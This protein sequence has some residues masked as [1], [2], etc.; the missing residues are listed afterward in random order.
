VKTILAILLLSCSA[1]WAQFPE[2]NTNGLDKAHEMM[3]RRAMRARAA[4]LTND[5]SLTNM[6][7]SGATGATTP[8]PPTVGNPP[9]GPISPAG[10]VPGAIPAPVATPAAGSPNPAAPVGNV[11]AGLPNT[12]VAPSAPAAVPEQIIAAGE[13]DFPDMDLDQ[14]LEVYAQ[15]VGK[16]L[17][18]AQLPQV[19]IKL[20]TQTP[21]T[22]T[23]AIQALDSV[24]AMNGVTIIPVGDKFIKVVPLQQAFQQAAHFNTNDAS[25]LPEADQYVVQI[26]QVKNFKPSDAIQVLQPFSQI[27]NGLL[28]IDSNGILI[29]RDYAANVKRMLE[30]IKQ[31]DVEVPMDF[32]SEVIPIKYAQASEIA[33]A[34]SSLGGS[35]SGSIGKGASVGQGG[36]G[37]GRFGN[38]GGIGGGIG[39]QGG[40]GG[41]INNGIQ[42]QTGLGQP[43]G[44]N[45]GGLGNRSTSFGDRLNSIIKNAANAGEIKILGQTKIIADLRTN[46][47]L[48]FADKQDMEMIK[49]I[50]A[51]LDVVLAQVLIES[52]IMEVT[53]DK[54]NNIGFSYNQ[55]SF[56]T[57][58]NYF[59]GVGA[60]N[61]VGY[62]NPAN[63]LNANASSNALASGLSYFGNFGNDFQ[64]TLTA[65][66]TDDRINVL[67][68]PRIQTSHG[69]AATIQVGQT[70]PEV[71]GTY[72]GGINGQASSQYQ[73]QFVGISLTVTPLI[74]PE[75]LVVMDIQ[76]QVQAL[77]PNYTIDNNTVPSTTTRS[78]SSTVSVRNKETIILGGM[79]S[80]TKSTSHSGVPLLKD[81]PGLGY[82]FRS[83]T[84][85]NQRVELIVLIHP[86]VLDT[87]EAAA[88][89]ATQEQN[90]MPGVK[91]AFRDN[92]IQ[93]NRLLKEADKI[94]V[95][96]TREQ[97]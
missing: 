86:T 81:I 83:S 78:A 33:S 60:I 46:S 19:K 54:G 15:L 89:V 14:V 3:L 25:T 42:G 4:G 13:I 56:S 35:T 31:I 90:N 21:L 73:Q 11:P 94:V 69:V 36:G 67:S 32:D 63:V 79:I 44:I 45:S 95:P 37:G 48:V 38:S 66:A 91:A 28:A 88:I 87:P 93:E 51:K 9:G 10:T 12:P 34:L 39:G 27:Q 59:S 53:L 18:R 61:N 43:G 80:S 1:V 97:P 49:K 84:D 92:Q 40:I 85:S 57:P 55:T 52:V 29:I 71:S 30:L 23:E 24:L 70:V 50:I 2:P 5:A 82:L 65:I 75:G 76:Q 16:T 74:N 77:G 64:A 68:R 20:R 41:G 7:V 22:K 6:P 62:L 17:L 96:K 58:G 8:V 72:F 26:I 47:L